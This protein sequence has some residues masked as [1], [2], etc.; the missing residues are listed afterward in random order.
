VLPD[1]GARIQMLRA[2]GHEILRSPLDTARHTDDPFFWGA[3][4]MAPWCGRIDARPTD[5]RGTTVDVP[6][7]FGDGTAIHGQVYGRPWQRDGEGEFSVVGGGN[8]WPWPYAV[9]I[10]F[11]IVGRSLRIDQSV[12]N[13]SELQ[14]PAGIGL[15][16]WF[17][18][19]VKVRINADRVFRSNAD[20]SADPENVAGAWDVRG[21]EGMSDGLDAT[22]AELGEPPVELHWP[23]LGVRAWLRMVA[24]AT[25]VVAASPAELDAIA[26]EPQTHAPQGLRRLI[27]G[28][29][30]AL[31]LLD[32]G[33]ILTLSTELSFEKVE[34][35]EDR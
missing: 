21:A 5:V 28:E 11:A 18:R 12:S 10:A 8:G 16:P 31:A 26:V 4:T 23:D 3:Y 13:Q 29:P 7:N 27:N 14:M 24:R 6:A 2:F 20:S 22:W 1:A 25:Y 15:H 33:G 30:G 35:E 32:P 19:P 34:E 17:R 9:S